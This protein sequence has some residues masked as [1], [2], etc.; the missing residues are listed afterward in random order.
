MSNTK[1]STAAENNLTELN[2]LDLAG[3]QGAAP[4]DAYKYWLEAIKRDKRD[5]KAGK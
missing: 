2:E 1:I 5:R 3:I 4:G